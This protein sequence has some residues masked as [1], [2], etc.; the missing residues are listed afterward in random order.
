MEIES[1]L[2][3]LSNH[4][5]AESDAHRETQELFANSLMIDINSHPSVVGNFPRTTKPATD[6]M[7]IVV[8][9]VKESS[10]YEPPRRTRK[11][12]MP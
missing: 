10:D 5:E 7:L 8:C 9:N 4:E 11:L 6:S 1:D 3:Q 12:L 2:F